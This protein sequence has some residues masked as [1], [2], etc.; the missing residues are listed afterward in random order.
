MP[1]RSRPAEA[2]PE[3]KPTGASVL[4]LHCGRV[5]HPGAFDRATSAV[6]LLRCPVC[7]SELIDTSALLE[8]DPGFLFGAHNLWNL[9]LAEP[10]GASEQH[11]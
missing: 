5:G 3:S 1:R 10:R 9:D 11:A 8:R 7:R 6:R 4:C 2:V